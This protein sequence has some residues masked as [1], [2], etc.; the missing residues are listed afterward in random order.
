[1]ACEKRA[2]IRMNDRKATAQD[3]LLLMLQLSQLSKRERII[4]VFVAA[5]AEI[6]PEDSILFRDSKPEGIAAAIEIR[7]SDHSY[8][9]LS[10]DAPSAA[11]EKDRDLLHNAAALLGI[12][13]RKNEQEETLTAEKT[14]LKILIEE[15]TAK[16]RESEEKFRN[17]FEHSVLGKSITTIEGK[18]TTNEAFRRILGYS[19]SELGRL[20]WPE[21][22]HPEE[23][24]R[25]KN[26]IDSILAGERTSARWEKRYIHKNGSIVWVDLSTAL[27]RDAQGRPLYFITSI[28]DITERKRNDAALR[29]SEN[30]LREAQGMAHLGFWNWDVKTGA[31]EWSEEVYRI[32]QLDPKEFTPRIDSILALSPWPEDHQRDRELIDRA[33]ETRSPGFYEQKFLHPDKSVGYYYS[34]FRGNYDEKG[35]LLSIVG[36]VL[37]ITERKR[38]EESLEKYSE[39]LLNLHR[40][41]TAI[42]QAIDTPEKIARTALLS[43]SVLLGCQRASI[44]I[45]NQGNMTAN[46]FAI[47][48]DET[49]VVRTEKK[50]ADSAY[51]DAAGLRQRSVEIVEDASAATSSSAIARGL[52]AEGIAAFINVPLI[53]SGTLIGALFIGWKAPRAITPEEKET[54]VEVANQIAIAFE[55]A[56]LLQETKR[57]AAELEGRVAERTAQLEASN[58]E[59][60][61]FSYSVSHD[62]RAPLRAIDG[63]V[64]I[65]L[66]DFTP[67]LNAEG[68]RI[69]SVIS[70]SARDM[71]KLIDNLLSFSR[72]GR[73]AM[74]PSVIDMGGM[75]YSVFF[76]LTDP[77]ERERIDF[78][79]APVQSSF[80]DPTLI[81]QAW[82][83]LISNAI[84]FSSKKERAKIDIDAEARHGELIYSICDNG[85]GF[86]MQYADK[87][88]GVFQ[89]LHSTKEFEGMGVGLAI[90]QRV[91]HRHGGRIW[92]EG[93]TGKGAAFYFTVSKGEA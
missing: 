35:G 23:I 52:L 36:T 82:I 74:Q 18:L 80:G 6:W 76:E 34:T 46:V 1:M 8:G 41:D 21:I 33:M 60:E 78:T 70:D 68:K 24:A 89:R 15:K 9:Y 88:F 16:I 85:V 83:N 57:Q 28:S 19:E 64:R 27:Q 12:I 51:G 63:Y 5:L 7:D 56:R 59:L 65:L 43:L 45:L 20:S 10:V 49:T 73:A 61:A 67:S 2:G 11:R 25:D 17:V 77:A 32:F 54:A 92:A 75:A 55:Q 29:E 44:G 50:L 86:D 84:K 79:V 47:D 53:S 26:I 30:K 13:L 62:L 22:T 31:V 42:L 38:A 3:L 81:R 87:L 40:I 93:E 69:C 72:L 14:D 71:G 66:E 48:I 39:R 90:V 37:D 58:Q 4:E 91:I